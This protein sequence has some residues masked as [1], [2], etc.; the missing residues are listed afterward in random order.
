MKNIMTNLNELK[1]MYVEKL[2]DK[3]SEQFSPFFVRVGEN[4]DGKSGVLFVGKADNQAG[5]HKSIELAFSHIQHD[6]IE[7]IAEKCKPYSGS[8]YVRTLHRIAKELKK[9]GI[10][11]FARTN[12][13]KLSNTQSHKFGSEYDAANFDIFRKEIEMLQPKYV[14]L[15]TSGMECP[16]LD[17]IGKGRDIVQSVKFNYRNKGKQQHKELKCIKIKG[18]D[19]IFITALHP[20]GKPESDMV[21]QIIG[22]IDKAESK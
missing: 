11:C 16:F 19:S 3:V 8:A 17:I 1:S 14:I 4:F 7:D 13:Y 6:Y 10:T 20:Q 12:L 9:K 15:F 2:G 21:K 5:Y 18:C 22:L